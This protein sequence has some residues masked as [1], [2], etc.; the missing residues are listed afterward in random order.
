MNEQQ[1]LLEISQDPALHRD[2]AT[3]AKRHPQLTTRATRAAWYYL[4]NLI[5]PLPSGDYYVHSENRDRTYNVT[6]NDITCNCPDVRNGA[7]TG[8]G[9]RPWC[10][11]MIAAVFYFRY[12]EQKR[13]I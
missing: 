13:E 1:A 3:L 8:P 12:Q 2:L 6:S 5:E 7:P 10:K 11:H 9:N 4:Q